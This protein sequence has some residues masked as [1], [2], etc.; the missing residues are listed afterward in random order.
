[1]SGAPLRTGPL[2][3]VALGAAL[4]SFSGVFVTVVDTPPT[5]S[6]FYRV[7]FGGLI[8]TGICL[9]RRLPLLGAA[10]PWVALLVAGGFFALDLAAWHR[11]I[12]YVGPGLATL[13]GNFQAFVLAVAGVLLFRERLRPGLLVAI[14]M[15]SFGLALIVGFEWLTLARD[16][17]LGVIFGLATAI[18]YA[19]YIL[20]LRH[21]RLAG[22]GRSPLADLALVSMLT[23]VLL[24]GG[25]L[26]EGQSLALGSAVDF[27]WL[28]AYAVVAQVLGWLLITS[29][30]ATAPASYVGLVLLLQPLLSFVWDVLFFGRAFGVSELIGAGLALVAIYLGSRNV[31]A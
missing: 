20:S 9:W 1:M 12:V 21:A 17:Q 7:L 13:L 6:A 30:L 4:I 18:F 10:T 26:L 16:V 15:A 14:P 24:A 2:L 19:C 11:S 25:A 5:V 31:A 22:H 23:A 27:G 8:L 29:G 28:V 3:R